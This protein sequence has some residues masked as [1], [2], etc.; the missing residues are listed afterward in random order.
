MHIVPSNQ[1]IIFWGQYGVRCPYPLTI[2]MHRQ[3]RKKRKNNRHTFLVTMRLLK[4]F[5][6]IPS[7]YKIIFDDSS[8]S[9]Y[10]YSNSGFRLQG[11]FENHR[12]QNPRKLVT[13]IIIILILFDHIYT[14]NLEGN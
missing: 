7:K 12:S 3:G 11:I 10:S 8:N 6:V 9:Y 4:Y 1:L 14:M 13:V 5:K 2:A